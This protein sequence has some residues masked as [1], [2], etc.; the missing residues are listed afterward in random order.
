MVG[1]YSDFI[2]NFS[3]LVAPLR[4]LTKEAT[5]SKPQFRRNKEYTH[6]STSNGIP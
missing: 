2:P 5:T 1:Y 6:E 4:K 3:K